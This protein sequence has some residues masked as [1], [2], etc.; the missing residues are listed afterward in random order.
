MLLA[1]YDMYAVVLEV[2]CK[3]YKQ[4][5]PYMSLFVIIKERLYNHSSENLKEVV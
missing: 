5:A 1:G 4:G 2:G 3:A